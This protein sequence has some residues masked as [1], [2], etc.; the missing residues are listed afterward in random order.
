MT[1]KTEYLQVRVTA[2][3]KDELERL[4]HED[5]RSAAGFIRH[6]IQKAIDQRG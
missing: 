6:L 2:E 1:D 4:A 3:M 5:G